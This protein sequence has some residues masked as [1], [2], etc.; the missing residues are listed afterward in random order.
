MEKNTIR[1]EY[2]TC[3]ICGKRARLTYEH[4]PPRSAFNSSKQL[5]YDTR[6]FLLKGEKRFE[7]QQRGAGLYSLCASCNNLTGKWY[8]AAY[9]D[10]AVQGEKYRRASAF[11]GIG[12]PYTIYPLRVFKQIISCFAS[13]NGPEWC[14]TKESI[15]RFLLHPQSREFPEEMDVLVYIQHNPSFKISHTTFQGDI[16]TGEHI[17]GSEWG[18]VPF[19]YVC[20]ENRYDTY[21]RAVGKM[22]SLRS[23]LKYSYNDYCKVYLMI[24][25][26]PCNALPFDYRSGIP[27]IKDIEL[28][29]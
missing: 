3:S 9:A 21:H 24:P 23:F 16:Y 26:M 5:M 27:S 22:L 6:S 15:R 17:I 7:T 25:Q 1:D 13:A 28:I 10:F 19:G 29:D 8:G 20:V 12:L 2:G 18:F 14:N 4:I 11:G